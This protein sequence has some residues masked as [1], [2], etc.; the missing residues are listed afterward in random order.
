MVCK[1]RDH[2]ANRRSSLL[3]CN[4]FRQRR[5]A[6]SSGTAL[7]AMLGWGVTDYADGLASK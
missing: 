1:R 7:A 2:S 4:Y 6:A 3:S 5:G